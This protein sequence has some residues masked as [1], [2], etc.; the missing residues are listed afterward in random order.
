[1]LAMTVAAAAAAPAFAQERTGP[2]GNAQLVLK[3]KEIWDKKRCAACHGISQVHS[4]PDLAGV[5]Q[6]RSREWLYRWMKE[7]QKMI[8][9]DSTA[10]AMF[11]EYNRLPM[12]S[13]KMSR[14][15]VDALLAFIDAEERRANR[16]R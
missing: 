12:P 1:V 2:A 15:D 14:G 3:G 5:S 11:Q 16:R 7:S 13:Q 10:Q 9:D 6:R 4:G 8:E